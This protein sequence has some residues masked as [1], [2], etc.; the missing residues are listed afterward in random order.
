[1]DA[2]VSKVTRA[3]A[4][5]AYNFAMWT[6]LCGKSRRRWLK[7]LFFAMFHEILLLMNGMEDC[8]GVE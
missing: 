7:A 6:A 5:R 8:I 1:L 3:F 4:V 2:E